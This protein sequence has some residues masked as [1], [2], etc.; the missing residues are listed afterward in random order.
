MATPVVGKRAAESIRRHIMADPR[1]PGAAN[2]RVAELGTPV[3]AL[4]PYLKLYDCDSTR[5]AAVAVEAPDL[6]QLLGTRPFGAGVI[7]LRDRVR[8]GA[9]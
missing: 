1:R 9:P 6:Q 8:D 5:E 7:H 4:V 2:A 3:W